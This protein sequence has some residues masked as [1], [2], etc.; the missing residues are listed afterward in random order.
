MIAIMSENAIN[1]IHDRTVIRSE[2]IPRVEMSIPT[3]LGI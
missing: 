1:E 2:Y 3:W